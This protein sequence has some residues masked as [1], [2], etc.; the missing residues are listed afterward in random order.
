MERMDG[1]HGW[2]AWMGIILRLTGAWDTIAAHSAVAS[3]STLDHGLLTVAR[4]AGGFL[5]VSEWPLPLV[6]SDGNSIALWASYLS[7][8]KARGGIMSLALI[9]CRAAHCR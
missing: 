6:K 2:G 9:S 8:D 3:H 1:A 5:S 7:D 4:P